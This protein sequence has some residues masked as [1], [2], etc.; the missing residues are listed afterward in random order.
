MARS[1]ERGG[2]LPAGG[3]KVK[4]SKGFSGLTATSAPHKFRTFQPSFRTSNVTIDVR[5][6]RGPRSRA[7]AASAALALVLA[8]CGDDPFSFNWDD[9]PVTTTLYSLSR[10]ELNLPAA[11]NFFTSAAIRVEAPN[12]TGTWDLAV[13]TR[14][15]ELVFLPPGALGVQSRARIASLEGLGL[16]DVLEAPGDTAVFVADEPVPARTGTV[17]V[18]R[19]ERRV[20]SFGTRGNNYAKLEVVSMD[21]AAGTLTFRS[22]TNPICNDRRL[23]PPD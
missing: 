6:R 20:C 21:A 18:V 14:E 5:P 8:S 2:N 3:G 10:P 19:T 11:Y 12:A 22:V 4:Q 13:G 16:D 17:Y 9:E 7:L 1:G 15:G 23:V